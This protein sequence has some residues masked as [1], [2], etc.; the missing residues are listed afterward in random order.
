M[1]KK[2]GDPLKNISE[3]RRKEISKKLSE[4]HK[5]IFPTIETRKKLSMSRLG[6][7]N[8]FF[9]RK[10]SLETKKKISQARKKTGITEAHRIQ[11]EK[12]HESNRQKKYRRERE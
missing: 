7:K 4:S 8:H 5:G 6:E 2:R 12:L 10:H 1:F 3:Q 11:L 9:G